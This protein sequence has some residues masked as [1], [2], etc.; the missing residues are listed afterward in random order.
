MGINIKT[1]F[2]IF[3]IALLFYSGAVAQESNSTKKLKENGV[4]K[5][6][7]ICFQD[8]DW[9]PYTFGPSSRFNGKGSLPELLTYIE[10][11]VNVKFEF[12]R[13][14]GK[15]VKKSLP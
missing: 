14:H 9:P 3:V 5:K 15:D 13:S 2:C 4:P 8:V 1:A 11:D 6:I 7:K 12:L 10:K